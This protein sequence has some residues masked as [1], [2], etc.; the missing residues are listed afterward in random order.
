MT[1]TADNN[2][3][4]SDPRR[5]RWL[6]IWFRPGDTIEQIISASSWLSVLLL[7]GLGG[8]FGLFAIGLDYGWLAMDWRN[9]AI[10]TVVGFVTGVVGLFFNAF[11]YRLWGMLLG[12]HASQAH[13]RAALAWSMLPG[14]FGFVICVA[15]VIGLKLVGAVTS[16]Q[17]AFDA[18]DVALRLVAGVAE[19]WMLVLTVITIKRIQRFGIWRAIANIVLGWLVG[20]V[21]LALTIRI[22]LFQPFSIPSAAMM[23]TL[24][25]GDYIFVSKYAYGYTHFSVPFSPSLFTGRTFPVEPQR[26]DVAVFRLPRNTTIDYVERIVGL[27]GDRIQ[28]KDG[29]LIINNVPVKRERVEDFIDDESGKAMR[30]WRETLPNGVSFFALDLLDNGPFDNTDIYIVP[31]GHYFMLGDNHDNSIDSR[32]P[33]EHGGV[34]YVPFEN[35]IG[36]VRIIFF[37]IDRANAPQPRIRHQRIGTAVR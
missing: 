14:V 25:V 11:F 19:L 30:C 26:G 34:G 15:A 1:A 3:A 4:S 24:L 17:P 8:A 13:I 5:S 7:A 33:A 21:A 10:L 35:L 28:M 31:S 9:L 29:V 23:P 32:I 27:P 36:R 20:G 2:P 37:S 12:G 6:S 22:F 16:P 18:V